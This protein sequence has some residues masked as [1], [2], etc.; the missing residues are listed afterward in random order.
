EAVQRD[1]YVTDSTLT[2]ERQANADLIFDGGYILPGLVDAHAHLQ[3]AS[4]VAGSPEEMARASAKAHLDVGVLAIREP[5]APSAD[6]S[7]GVGPDVGLPRTIT[8]GRPLAPQGV[9]PG[10]ARWVD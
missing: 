8:A 4:P 2:F 9:Y 6:G 3:I 7:L 10:L 1:V 5:G